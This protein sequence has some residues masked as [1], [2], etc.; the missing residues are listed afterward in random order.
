MP[1]LG[2]PHALYVLVLLHDVMSFKDLC[3]GIKSLSNEYP[4]LAR[5]EW[6]MWVRRAKLSEI[7]ASS[8]I[9]T[10][11]QDMGVTCNSEK[12]AFQ[13]FRTMV[14]VWGGLHGHG[15]G[16]AHEPGRLPMWGSTVDQGG[17]R[18]TELRRLN[19][20]PPTL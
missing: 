12:R 16:Q 1:D 7:Y 11:L 5:N 8:A 13:G 2:G 9:S 6:P 4:V 20:L 10:V 15:Q 14:S 19:R 3:Q 17:M 18:I